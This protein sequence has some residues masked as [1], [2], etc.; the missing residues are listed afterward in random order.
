MRR[1]GARG[2][3]GMTQSW[4]GSRVRTADTRV[5][6]QAPDHLGLLLP[7]QAGNRGLPS[8]SGALRR[9]RRAAEH[10]DEPQAHPL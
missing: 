7:G 3:Q 6:R 5:L 10:D 9:H 1:R 2:L 4:G 8:R